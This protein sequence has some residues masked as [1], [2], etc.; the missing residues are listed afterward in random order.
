MTQSAVY[1]TH[2]PGMYCVVQ[3]QV[4]PTNPIFGTRT[5]C[6]P[7]IQ[8]IPKNSGGSGRN[9]I[10]GD[11][12]CTILRHLRQRKVVTPA[13]NFSVVT[14]EDV[15]T[16]VEGIF[17]VTP[18]WRGICWDVFVGDSLLDEM[19]KFEYLPIMI[20]YDQVTCMWKTGYFLLF[21]LAFVFWKKR[22]RWLTPIKPS[23][24]KR[25]DCIWSKRPGSVKDTC[26]WSDFRSRFIRNLPDINSSSKYAFYRKRKPDRLPLSPWFRCYAC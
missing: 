21:H 7:F 18:L 15:K 25:I 24:C 1:A 4:I 17:S 9:M 2:I 26:A 16:K 5:A 8:L 23:S 22:L 11:T 12:E 6:W 13:V 14:F 20:I 10:G 19:I 3:S